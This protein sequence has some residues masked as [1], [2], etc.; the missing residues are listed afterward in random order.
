VVVETEETTVPLDAGEV[1][2]GQSG[3]VEVSE[4]TADRYLL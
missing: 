4:E 1:D 2:G 3:V